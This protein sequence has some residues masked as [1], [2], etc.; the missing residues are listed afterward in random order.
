MRSTK[1]R[2][3]IP[4]AGMCLLAVTVARAADAKS[5]SCAAGDTPCL[6]QAIN[7]AN[8]SGHHRN[9]IRLAAGTYT[10]YDADN[11][12]DGSNGLPSISSLLTIEVAGK[13]TAILTR[14]VDAP[15]FRLLHVTAS[16]RLTLRGIAVSNGRIVLGEGGAGVL[17][18]GGDVTIDE[19][20]FL[21]NSAARSGGAVKSLGGVVTIIRSV[22]AR[23]RSNDGA[24]GLLNSGGQVTITDSVFDQNFGTVGPGA[25][26]NLNEGT[27]R[28]VASQITNNGGGF[29]AGGLI[30]VGGSVSIAKTTFAGNYADGG[31][32]IR[33]GPGT[34]VV[35][36]SAF[37]GN[38]SAY[39][40]T[41]LLVD[42]GTVDVTNTTFACHVL[43]PNRVGIPHLIINGRG[44][45]TLTNSTFFE[46][47]V[48]DEARPPGAPLD[49]LLAGGLDGTTVLQNTILAHAVTE[50]LL[51][52]WLAT[53]ASV[54]AK[55][56][57]G[58]TIDSNATA[59][60]AM[61]PTNI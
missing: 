33:V 31:G 9:T 34:L 21:D 14:D 41:A 20:A 47:T 51:L 19:C 40:G 5:F 7:D 58:S 16:G 15:Y 6:I 48:S 44:A 59:V 50:T 17:N 10:L 60:R 26:G 24:G 2:H 55:A 11:D 52:D 3:P 53:Y 29:D 57:Q 56:S 13:G 36:D 54:T 8:M 28:I 18:R 1:R 49:S 12:T 43:T 46:N 23:N 37:V 35:T 38:R 25:L 30:M 32:A 42:T 27:M 39:G 22:F 4:V 45:L 61:T